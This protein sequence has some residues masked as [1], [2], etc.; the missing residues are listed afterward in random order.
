MYWCHLL[1]L[2]WNKSIHII[3]IECYRSKSKLF[4]KNL[5]TCNTLSLFRRP[6]LCSFFPPGLLLLVKMSCLFNTI[7]RFIFS[8]VGVDLINRSLR[9][10]EKG[11]NFISIKSINTSSDTHTHTQTHPNQ[12]F[13]AIWYKIKI[14]PKYFPETFQHNPC[15]TSQQQNQNGWLI[16][17]VSVFLLPGSCALHE[18]TCWCCDPTSSEPWQVRRLP[19]INSSRTATSLI[20]VPHAH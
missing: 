9:R 5:K 16:Q 12:Q 13:T 17:Y 4:F 1:T 6:Y 2:T 7:G 15:A 19:F 3:F 14:S 10:V 11:K 18:F 8:G 20:S